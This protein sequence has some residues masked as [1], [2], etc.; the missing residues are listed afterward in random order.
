[1][2]T[3]H[4][5]K[6]LVIEDEES[7]FLL[8]EEALRAGGTNACCTRVFDNAALET[9]LTLRPDLVLSDYQVP[10][11]TLANS[12]MRISE[13]DPELPVIL[14]SGSVTDTIVVDLLHLGICDFV[15]KDGLVRLIPAVKRAV[16]KRN[17]SQAKRQAQSLVRRQA[18][19]I[20]DTPATVIITDLQGLV[21]YWNKGAE[22]L[23]GYT[24]AEAVGRHISFIYFEEDHESLK[25]DVIAPLTRLGTH[26]LENRVRRH[27]GREMHQFLSLS[28]T[29]DD[30]R[31]PDGMISYGVDIT[32]RKNAEAKNLLLGEALHQA[33]S[34]ILLADTDANITYINPAFT[35]LFGYQSSDLCGGS[36]KQ[37][38]P[39][40]DG[41]EPAPMDAI[42]HLAEGGEWTTESHRIAKDGASIPVMA[43]VGPI[44]N[45]DEQILGYVAS[46]FD[47]RDIRES[48]SKFRI[49]LDLSP[50]AVFIVA[51]DG[52]FTY[53]NQ[54]A[55]AL[56]GYSQVE[57][58]AMGV[59]SLMAPDQLSKGMAVLSRVL[60]GSH[61]FLETALL[62]RSGHR[63]DVEVNGVL[64]PDGTVLSELRDI[65]GQKQNA[66]KIKISDEALAALNSQLEARIAERTSHLS[67]AADSAHIGIWDY[68]IAENRIS[69]NKWM[70]ELYGVREEDFGGAYEAWRA[71][72]HPDD[73]AR[74]D[75]EIDQALRGEKE[76]DTEFRVV[77]PSGEVRYIKANALVQRDQ[78]GVAQRMIGV[79]Y[80]IT[81]IRLAE[82]AKLRDSGI[83]LAEAQRIGRIGSYVTDIQSGIW[84]S[85]PVLDEI[86]G[87]DGDFVRSIENWGT[88]MA[89]GYGP[90][91]VDYF[92][93]VV[94]E[95]GRFKKEYEIVRRS[96]GERRWVS[97]L[98]EFTF[99]AEGQPLR[100][101]G[102][103]QDIT[104]R[105]SAELAL[106][107]SNDLLMKVIDAIPMRVFWKD[108]NLNFIGCN[109]AF[110]QD[111]GQ[112]SPAQIIGKND[113]Q[114]IWAALADSYRADDRQLIASGIAKIAYE[115]QHTKPNGQNSWVRSSKIPLRSPE[116]EIF[117]VLGIYEDISQAKELAEELDSYRQGL[118][119]QVAQRTAELSAARLQ[120][121][122]ANVAKSDFLAN[123]SHEIRSPL[124]AILGLAY[125]L[126]QSRLDR[127]DHVMVQ[128]IRNSGRMLLGI[129]S[130]ILDM[131]KIEAGQLEVEQTAF[132]LSTVID[133]VAVA[134]GLAIG[135]KD[136][137][138]IVCPL[139]HGIIRIVGDALRLQQVLVNLS[140]NA[141]KFTE[142]G[143]IELRMDL[144]SGPDGAELLRFCMRDTGIGIAPEVQKSVFSAFSQA[145]TS[146]TRRFGGTGLGLTICRQ[147]VNLM[148]GE[149]GVNSVPGVGSE[150]WFVLPLQRAAD[151][152]YSSPIRVDALIVDDSALTLDAIKAL[153]LS[154][155]WTVS[156][157][158][159]GAAAL[160]HLQARKGLSFPNV[161]VVDWKM[162]G[163]DGL[164]T[165]CAIR[166]SSPQSEC[167]IVLMATPA[168]LNLLAGQPG[169]D[170][171]DA[172]LSKPV[173][174]SGMYNAVMQGWRHRANLSGNAPV[175]IETISDGLAG[176]RVL[177]VDDSD[178]NRDVA[179]RI[180]EG[181][182]A[183][184]ILA[185]DGQMAFDWLLAHPLEVDLVLMD[186]Q[187]PVLD[188]MEATRRL[189]RIGQFDDLPIVALTA[190][191]FK[192]QQS[193]AL[194][195]G[196]THFVSKPFDVP[197]TIAL[198]QRLRR[199][200]KFAPAYA[201]GQVVPGVSVQASI[202]VGE[203]VIATGV[204]D[205]AQGLKLWSDVPTYQSYL[206]RFVDGYSDAAESMRTSVL[207]GEPWAA[208]ALAHKLSGVAANL[209]LTDTRRA[210][211]ELE[212]VLGTQDD[213]TQAVNAL[214]T[215]IDTALAEIHQYAPPVVEAALAPRAV[216]TAEQ[217]SELNSQLQA[218]LVVL[219][220]DNA[221]V[222]KRSLAI[223]AT[224][225]PALD[226]TAILGCVLAYDFRGAEA[227]TRQLAKDYQVELGD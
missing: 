50:N 130:D 15:P 138:L 92:Y 9:V 47:L 32:A 225:L 189:R 18:R 170:L 167:P 87:I 202:L 66:I 98:G 159:S 17:L 41:S 222:V 60:G 51:P 217:K 125:L 177:V 110:A 40:D 154:M 2:T 151:T 65:T 176:V 207:N 116:G 160:A 186:V 200:S 192:S 37:I 221:S 27:C 166:E 179:R 198:I 210:A 190:G 34:P 10:G 139:P 127:N 67:L 81:A 205:V 33:K 133:N 204:M 68:Q 94:R 3:T 76:F 49:A 86:F 13:I 114:I 180:L 70:F 42:R 119:F 175:Q 156:T 227:A 134:M 132:D 219:D 109:A 178:I 148:G 162:P 12:M 141:A 126:E 214:A 24:A 120:A 46:Y 196:M 23:L 52:N 150:F 63:I 147:L 124:N 113:F 74:G 75:A 11:M 103:I 16:E 35:T 216:L 118:E 135:E 129:I 106:A 95:K 144:T 90:L 21:T 215:A 7:D 96:D 88:L 117:G 169:A 54:R 199:P 111:A 112:A 209:A 58:L 206:R 77:W 53:V 43:H 25:L 6:V 153:A 182:G 142:S 131:S 223:W 44:R 211:Q 128:R 212:R 72:L 197:A 5:L 85:S 28:L 226:Q 61:E 108:L 121:E 105:K 195:A 161:V 31:V 26:S 220:S 71:G 79:N 181:E 64:L 45:S 164:A 14:F 187:M 102:T 30:N 137:E 36:I 100:L 194:N 191:A 213:P 69:W 55:T 145:D 183:V 152:R 8:L 1:M 218:L 184:V 158:D 97:A 48:E 73:V 224:R 171:V 149:I 38:L 93:Q 101:R 99:D 140:S 39:P 163:M 78:N 29:F 84:K 168:M 165:A 89:P 20:T 22:V 146:T 203:A 155:N 122:T 19:I 193:A 172:V 82:Q 173:T 157:V 104:E 57:L 91:M 83:D 4:A 208:A 62:H 107:A 188:G 185:E 174:S 59:A 115:E 201:G 80:D 123:M 143:R 136:I 56:V